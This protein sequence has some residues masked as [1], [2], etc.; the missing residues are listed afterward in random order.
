MEKDVLLLD[1]EWEFKEFPETA[2]RMRDLDGDGWMAAA[3]P[4]S[5]YTSLA[6]A[7][8][9]DVAELTANP[10]DFGWVSEKSWIFRKTFDVSDALLKKDRIKLTF[11]GLDTVSQIWL[12]DK[13]IGKTENMFIA[14]SFD[15][16][17]H[18]QPSGN[19]LLIKF[20]PALVCADQLMQ[21]YGKLSEHHFGDLRR[22][23]LRK[24]QYQFGSV[25]GPALPGCGIFRSVGIEGFN[26]AHIDDLHVRTVDCN[27]HYADIRVA[28]ALERASAKATALHG[29][30][31]LTGGGLDI[32]Q[33]L[34]FLPQEDG[35]A[36]LIHIDRPFL[37]WP[38][39]YG[40]QHLYHLKADLFEGEHLLD[41]TETDFGIRSIRLNRSAD[42]Q[43]TK[44]EFVVN[45]QPIQVKGA[46]WMPLSMFPGTQ[47]K[48]DY[49]AR[50]QQAAEA[51][52]NLLRVWGGGYYE[53]PDFYRLCDRLGILVWQDFMFASAYY[54]DRRW[55]T[56]MV[57]EEAAAMI[58]R[59][60][61]H[62]CLAAWCGNSRIDS[63]HEDGR[64]GTGRKFYGKAIYHELL[65][66][67]LNEL[68]PDREYI[69]TTPFSEID[70]VSYHDPGTGTIHNWKIW[71]HYADRSEY[72]TSAEQTPRFV[73]EFGLQSLPGQQ[74]LSL[75]AS[76]QELT[77]GS[78]RLEKHNYQPGGMQRIV[79]YMADDFVPSPEMDAFTWQSQV[80]QARGVKR[81][82]EHL[83][84]HRT[85][86]SGC[87]VWTF[88]D[89]TP[90]IGFSMV[91][92]AGQPKAL[93]YYAKRFFAPVL[94][95]LTPGRVSTANQIAVVNDSPHRITGT[96]DCR[97]LDFAGHV[98]DQSQVPIALAAFARSNLYPVP[99]SLMR[100]LV[101]SRSLLHLNLYTE[102][103]QLAENFY[104]FAPDKYCQRPAGDIDLDILATDATTWQVS[105]SSQTVMTDLQLVLPCPGRL[106]DNFFTLMPGRGKTIEVQFDNA[107][108]SP[109]TPIRILSAGWSTGA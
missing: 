56:E 5:I 78:Y 86:N 55:F 42:E 46:N 50:L 49:D 57:K 59:L 70:G 80:T 107:A 15:I 103:S 26:T 106:S 77:P 100:S 10:E 58:E 67:L 3:V 97:V 91:D 102:D 64:L 40:V 81:Y 16:T 31:H 35:H 8:V 93:Y 27:Q 65:P 87:V 30:L 92:A 44:F 23:Y 32:S 63:L 85:I 68:D 69:P 47:T 22:S 104:F 89:A 41:T 82:A 39:G 1:G 74:T 84:C 34:S 62:A 29:T 79:R 17:Q 45:E 6:A 108:P 83:R 53:N 7:G 38:K 9:I 11:E 36:T 76:K 13:L 2:R 105:L 4:G 61:N 25:M 24:A 21:R 75:F 99:K 101:P 37:W 33:P 73:T 96:L 98:L 94:A 54:P 48:A 14:H 18:L 72:E 51:H 109:C 71:N 52:L 90:S 28:V 95:A 20:R 12:N 43:G 66:S 19:V 60:R 88:N